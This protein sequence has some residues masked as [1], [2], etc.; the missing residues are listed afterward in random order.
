M[1]TVLIGFPTK[2]MSKVILEMMIRDARAFGNVFY[3]D[4]YEVLYHHHLSL[5]EV[6]ERAMNVINRHLQCPPN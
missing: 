2:S 6:R 1:K 3:I 5:E 4:D